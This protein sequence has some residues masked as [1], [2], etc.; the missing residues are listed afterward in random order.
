MGEGNG[1]EVNDRGRVPAE[2]RDAFHK[3][4]RQT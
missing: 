3:A 4:H 2:I 1:Y